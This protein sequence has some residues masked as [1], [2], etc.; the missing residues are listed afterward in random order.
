MIKAEKIKNN[1]TKAVEV[2]ARG[3]LGDLLAEFSG[4][5]ISLRNSDVE[6]ELLLKAFLEGLKGKDKKEYEITGLSDI[7][8]FFENQNG[9]YEIDI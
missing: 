5:V 1:K 7:V 4:I 6:E 2:R 3:K 9:G 8:D